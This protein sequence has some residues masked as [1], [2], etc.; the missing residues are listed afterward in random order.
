M[1]GD[2]E[3]FVA[4]AEAQGLSSA[5]STCLRTGGKVQGEPHPIFLPLAC[6]AR[7]AEGASPLDRP[8]PQLGYA[9]PWLSSALDKHTS[10]G[11]RALSA[12]LTRYPDRVRT[13][14]ANGASVEQ[15][16][17]AV[18]R[19]W[20]WMEGGR[21]D[22]AWDYPTARTVD[23]HVKARTLERVRIHPQSLFEAFGRDLPA[24]HMARCQSL[25][26]P[27]ASRRPSP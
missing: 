26:R 6:L 16:Q 1:A 20:F 10:E 8:V 19:L 15:V 17:E 3:A 23:A 9:G 11:K 24:W 4:A 5:E 2:W 22:R 27:L 14:Q 25:P 7:R 18:G 21:L 13:L 12:L